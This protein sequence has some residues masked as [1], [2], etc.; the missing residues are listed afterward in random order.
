MQTVYIGSNPGIKLPTLTVGRSSTL[1]ALI[2]GMPSHVERVQIHFGTRDDLSINA[3]DCIPAPGGEWKCYANGFYF[4]D[5]G[6]AH[7]YVVA[8][9]D[10]G[11]SEYFGRGRLKIVPSVAPETA[12][13]GI[14]P[15]D[16]YIRNPLT[17]L[18]HKISAELDEET[19][20]ITLSVEQEGITR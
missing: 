20:K 1:R 18:W 17:G 12:N 6:E 9:D 13:A 14:I 4:P 7:Y 15:E 2:A 16:S 11:G 19:G 5:V 8:I 3:V 10:N